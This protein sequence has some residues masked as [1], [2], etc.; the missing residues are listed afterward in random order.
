MR[1]GKLTDRQ[2]RFCEYFI[3]LGNACDA[4]E[5]AGFQRS[6]AEGAKRQPAVQEYLAELRSKLPASH[7]EIT[8]FLVGVMRGNIK[9]SDLRTE[10]AYQMGRRA[11]LWKGVTEYEKM[12]E[13]AAANE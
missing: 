6:Y 8:N 2:R 12:I 9:A 5:K 13:E 10:A 1:K 3:E 11:G 4:A 7:T